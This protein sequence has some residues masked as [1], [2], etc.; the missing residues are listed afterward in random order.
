MLLVGARPL[1][2]RFGF[3][4]MISNDFVNIPFKPINCKQLAE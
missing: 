2:F 4:R 3:N 1:K